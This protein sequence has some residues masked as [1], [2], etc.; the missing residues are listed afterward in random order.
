MYDISTSPCESTCSKLVLFLERWGYF[1]G[2]Y[3]IEKR[4]N[5]AHVHSTSGRHQI[6]NQLGRGGFGNSEVHRPA[7]D[8]FRVS[9]AGYPSRWMV[10]FLGK[11]IY[12]GMTDEIKE[13]P[14][15]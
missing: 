6:V 13:V 8:F 2:S 14:I 3:V 7:A 15:A 11:T 10:Y 9:I 4:S 5:V 12:K 1:F